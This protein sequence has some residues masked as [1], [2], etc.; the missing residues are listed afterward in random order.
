MNGATERVTVNGRVLRI[1]DETHQKQIVETAR[2]QLRGASGKDTI[3]E[4]HLPEGYIVRFQY[5]PG[6]SEARVCCIC[7]VA[8]EEG[9]V[10]CR[11]RCCEGQP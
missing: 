4:V 2:A 11:G 6:T 8:N 10:V 1:F 9:V 5:E 3:E 7:E